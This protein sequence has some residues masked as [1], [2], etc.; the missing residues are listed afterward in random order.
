MG[1]GKTSVGHRLAR[2]LGCEFFDTDNELV[3]HTGVSIASI[4]E[5]EGEAEFRKRESDTLKGLSK[6]QN[7]VIATGGG[8]VLDAKNRSLLQTVGLVIYLKASVA[9]LLDHTSKSKGRPL[10]EN[11][12][13]KE[14]TI[15]DLLTQRQPLYEECADLT[16]NTDGKKLYM[17]ISEIKKS[18]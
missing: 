5:I 13:D 10:L 16:I 9:R 18:L 17:I 2:A 8:I 1:V 6:S 14:K 11:S 7:V 15:R 12:L 3:R 4:F